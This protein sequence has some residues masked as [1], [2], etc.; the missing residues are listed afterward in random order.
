MVGAAF[1]Y[2]KLDLHRCRERYHITT[3]YGMSQYPSQLFTYPLTR[4]P[5]G[6]SPACCMT[7]HR[8]SRHNTPHYTMSSHA[9]ALHVTLR[10]VTPH[11]YD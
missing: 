8:T 3:L 4:L 6:P 7:R 1:G 9:I 10:Q 11:V 2:P 5:L